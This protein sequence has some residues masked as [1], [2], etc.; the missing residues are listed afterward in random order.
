M[1]GS[2]WG[3]CP[4]RMPFG[5]R[6]NVPGDFAP[7]AERE[8]L[9]PRVRDRGDFVVVA[10]RSCLGIR[11]SVAVDFDPRDSWVDIICVLGTASPHSLKHSSRSLRVANLCVW[12]REAASVPGDSEGCRRILS[13]SGDRIG[14]IIRVG[15]QYCDELPIFAVSEFTWCF[16]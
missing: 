2:R 6:D 7:A 5:P 1:A 16:K 3:V 11:D 4:C 8:S 15:V 14:S 9:R 12:P 10:G 13:T